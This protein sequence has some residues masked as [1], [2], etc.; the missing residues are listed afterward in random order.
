MR[1][2]DTHSC[3]QPRSHVATAPQPQPQRHS[4][5]ATATAPQQQR[6]RKPTHLDDIDGTNEVVQRGG[7]L[8][9]LRG[10]GQRSG[11]TRCRSKRLHLRQHLVEMPG[12]RCADYEDACITQC[13]TSDGHH[14]VQGATTGRARQDLVDGHQLRHHSLR[15]T[16]L[17][18]SVGGVGGGWWHGCQWNLGCR[19]TGVVRERGEPQ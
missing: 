19:H 4:H 12:R 11:I 9:S 2:P 1:Q 14:T 16:R 17:C 3:R 6:K 13:G 8:S 18:V 15:H 7:Q 5:S 10:H